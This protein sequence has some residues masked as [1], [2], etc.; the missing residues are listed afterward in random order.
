MS[1]IQITDDSKF[2]KHEDVVSRKNANDIVVLMKMDDSSSFFKIN[3]VAAEVWELIDSGLSVKEVIDKL[4]AEYNVSREQLQG[5]V[6]SLL[7]NLLEKEL[8]ITA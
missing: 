4:T 7:T 2:Q 6:N 5:D 1:D 8:A 3:G